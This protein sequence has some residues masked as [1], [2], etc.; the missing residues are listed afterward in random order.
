L[1]EIDNLGEIT[2]MFANEILTNVWLILAKILRIYRF[3]ITA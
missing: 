3:I 1:H 2:K